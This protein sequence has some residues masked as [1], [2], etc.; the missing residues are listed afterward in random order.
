VHSNAES[1]WVELTKGEKFELLLT[2]IELGSGM[3]GSEFARRA[4]ALQPSLP[5]LL[6]SGYSKHLADERREDP[7]R[8]P[9][10][11]KPF[12]KEELSAAASLALGGDNGS[13]PVSVSEAAVGSVPRCCE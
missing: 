6:T 10:L 11:K 7:G 9:V 1:A 5:V 4:R 12:S 8:W 13:V 3:K 2:D